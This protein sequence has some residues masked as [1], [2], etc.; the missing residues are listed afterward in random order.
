MDGRKAAD[1]RKER[2]RLLPASVSQVGEGLKLDEGDYPPIGET[3]DDYIPGGEAFPPASKEPNQLKADAHIEALLEAFEE[4]LKEHPIAALHPNFNKL[5]LREVI[6]TVAPYTW[7][8]ALT[9]IRD[10]V[11]RLLTPGKK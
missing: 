9:D 10:G 3:P 7:E 11:K 6:H 4:C 5:E 1:E 2:V 8:D